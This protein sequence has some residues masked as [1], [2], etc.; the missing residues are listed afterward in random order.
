[1]GAEQQHDAA[2]EL[3]RDLAHGSGSIDDDAAAIREFVRAA[4]AAERTLCV[5]I[6]F[7]E[8]RMP[9]PTPEELAQIEATPRVPLARAVA[10]ATAKGIVDRICARWGAEKAEAARG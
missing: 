9:D 3:A 1:M 7:E 8:A 10:L 2:W 5:R 6:A 4:I